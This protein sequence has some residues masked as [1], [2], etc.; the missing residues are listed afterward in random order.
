MRDGVSTH[1]LCLLPGT[2][3]FGTGILTITHAA[4]SNMPA[5]R[6]II[7]KLHLKPV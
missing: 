2:S 4:I 7:P 1:I 6:A 3:P 5:A